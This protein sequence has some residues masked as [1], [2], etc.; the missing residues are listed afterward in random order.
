MTQ[1]EI[2]NILLERGFEQPLATHFSKKLDSIQNELQ[3]CLLAWINNNE[4]KDFQVGDYTISFFMDVFQMS[5]PAALVTMDWII[6]EPEKA[7]RAIEDG[8]A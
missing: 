6:R 2:Y 7:K 5:Y 8:I 3:P 4:E 1:Q